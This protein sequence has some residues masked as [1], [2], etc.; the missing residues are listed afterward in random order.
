MT[1]FNNVYFNLLEYVFPVSVFMRLATNFFKILFL[2]CCIKTHER[3]VTEKSASFWQIFICYSFLLIWVKILPK[4]QNMIFCK[5]LSDEVHKY[6]NIWRFAVGQTA[7]TRSPS[8][9]GG[10]CPHWA[11]PIWAW[12][13]RT[14]KR[15]IVKKNLL[16]HLSQPRHLET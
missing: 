7:A 9:E 10:S 6:T 14:P 16:C 2:V 3:A 11:R 15:K 1:C 13:E 12:K 5:K 8:I 4:I